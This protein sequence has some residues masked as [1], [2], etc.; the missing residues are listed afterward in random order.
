MSDLVPGYRIIGQIGVGAHSTIHHAIRATTGKSYAIKRVVNEGPDDAKFIAQ[1]EA[2]YQVSHA[3]K[4]P[5]LRYSYSIHRI[6][7]LL[8]VQEV[9]VVMEH[10]EGETLQDRRTGTLDAFLYIFHRIGAGLHA[11][12][13]AGYVHADIKPNNIIVGKKEVVKI[14]DFGQACPMWH[15]KG[16]IQGT[17]DYIAP[18]QVQRAPLDRRT[19]VFNLG[20][21]MYWVL[22]EVPFPTAIRQP[23]RRGGIDLVSRETLRTPREIN[24]LIPGPLSQLVMDCCEENPQGRPADMKAVMARLQV[25]Q[26]LWNKKRSEA[27]AKH[28]APLDAVRQGQGATKDAPGEPAGPSP[29]TIKNG[30]GTT[31][32]EEGKTRDE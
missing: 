7:K 24:P 1:V 4:H 17:P 19:D 20:A 6:K 23:T 18:E 27:R 5:N 11:L 31:E 21:T 2:E 10:V 15:R 14:I 29:A 9:R 32:T 8:A 28:K 26:S 25:V 3:V 16:R 30:P 13:E 22:T 12:H